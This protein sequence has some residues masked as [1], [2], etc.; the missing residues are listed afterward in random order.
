MIGVAIDESVDDVLPWVEGVTFPV[1]LDREHLLTDLYAISNVPTVVWIDERDRIARPN[2][3]AFGTD[4]FKDFTGVA[5]GP[6]KD[7]IARWART[8]EVEATPADGGGV[9]DLTD[10]EEQARL[11]FRVGAWL[12]RTGRVD[13]AA[14]RFERAV[15][16]AP[17]DF[18]IRRA[19][20]PLV[21]TDPF[22]AEFFA[23][24]QEWTDAGRPYNGLMAEGEEPSS[25]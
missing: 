14:A 8:G 11:W 4:T 2:T 6:H 20:M 1:L 18:T 16:L 19:A 9:E 23:L 10:D 12:R 22:G 3:V 24:Y 21:G 13:E 25:S 15:A 5:S 7:A 17:M